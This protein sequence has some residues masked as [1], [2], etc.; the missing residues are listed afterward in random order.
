MT[1][2]QDTESFDF[3]TYAFVLVIILL[4]GEA[5]LAASIW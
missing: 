5:I 4:V 2:N 1:A 3:V